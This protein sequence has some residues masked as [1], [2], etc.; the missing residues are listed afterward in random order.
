MYGDRICYASLFD[1][2][3]KWMEP[4]HYL[5]LYVKL[6]SVLVTSVN[7]NQEFKLDGQGVKELGKP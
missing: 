5:E 6:R 1:I 7:M 3:N 4:K 2:V